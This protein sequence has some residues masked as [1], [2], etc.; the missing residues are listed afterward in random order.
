MLLHITIPSEHV[1]PPRG[2]LLPCA[3]LAASVASNPDSQS[4]AS[5]QLVIEK[6]CSGASAKCITN[7]F[8]ND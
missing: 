8:S 2:T 4:P 6:V 3:Q 1:S 5:A 7:R